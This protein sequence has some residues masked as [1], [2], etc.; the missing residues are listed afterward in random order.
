MSIFF[1]GTKPKPCWWPPNPYPEDLFPMTI[2]EVVDVIPDPKLRTAIAGCLCRYG[3]EVASDM[4][5][6]SLQDMKDNNGEE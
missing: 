4:I 5:F 2:K 1:G 6:K 3:W